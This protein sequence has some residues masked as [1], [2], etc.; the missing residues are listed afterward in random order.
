MHES[1]GYLVY[2]LALLLFLAN[3][4]DIIIPQIGQ[5][6][7]CLELFRFPLGQRVWRRSTPYP[8]CG[9]VLTTPPLWWWWD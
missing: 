2:G 8:T 6:S 7:L 4:E 5:T 1:P 9:T 3:H